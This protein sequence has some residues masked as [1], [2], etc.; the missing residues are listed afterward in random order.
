MGSELEQSLVHEG[1]LIGTEISALPDG[2]VELR[3]PRVPFVA[4]PWEWP[5]AMWL[6]AAD[7]TLDLCERLVAQDWILKDATP[8]NVLFH[9]GRPIFIDVPSVQ[10]MDPS[11]P[12]WFAYAQFMRTFV[13]PLLA[14]R[15]LG[16]DLRATQLRRDG[17]EPGEIARAMP[18]GAQLRPSMFTSVTL[19]AMLAGRTN[20]TA[21]A[22]PARR[23]PASAEECRY[24]LGRALRGARRKLHRAAAEK[25]DRGSSASGMHRWADY[26]GTLHHYGSDDQG[27]KLAFVRERLQ[28]IGPRRLLDVGCNTGVYS[29]MAADLGAEVVS[30]DTDE[31]SL[32]RLYRENA[33]ERNILPLQID[34]ARP[35]PGTGW[36]N[37]ETSSF[38]ARAKGHFDTVLMLAVMHHLLLSDQIPLQHIAEMCS[39][40]TTRHLLLEWVPPHDPMFRAL[41]R[42]RDAIYGH[43]TEEAMRSSL[44][45]YFETVAEAPL[46]N[47]RILLHLQR[48]P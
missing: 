15:R 4:Y 46:Q 33:G 20:G 12:L 39:R 5:A 9:R 10:P 6:A 3:H 26:A 18:R 47:G 31:P 16:W 38:L 42:G 28:A 23:A 19:P 32:S 45:P 44:L 40:L 22:R 30:I 2:E 29:R 25:P 11:L 21:S 17:Y 43:I 27:R 48:R 14:F 1:W 36:Q 8:L 37:C 35:T 24:I 41:L 34:L 7:L 13:L